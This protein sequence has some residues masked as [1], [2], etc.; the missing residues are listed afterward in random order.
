MEVVHHRLIKKDL[1]E[2]L[3]YYDRE[4]GEKLGDRFFEEAEATVDRI[5]ANPRHFHFL[6]ETL[7]KASLKNFPYHFLFEENSARV[8]ILVL[9]HDKR[10]PSYGLRRK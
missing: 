8:K 6:S 10:H 4:G 7:R 1:R 9:R 5:L 2:A 3:T